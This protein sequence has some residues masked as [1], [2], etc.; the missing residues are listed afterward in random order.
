[1]NNYHDACDIQ[2]NT[3][4]TLAITSIPMQDANFDCV[5]NSEE[6]LIKGTVFPE[7]YLPFCGERGAK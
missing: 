4:Q 7:L 5:Y 1:M 2:N 3:V 6:G